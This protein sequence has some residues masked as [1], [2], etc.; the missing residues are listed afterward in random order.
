MAVL[1]AFKG[2]RPV[3]NK[4]KE[5]ASRPYDVLNCAEARK[6]ASGLPYSFLHVVKPEID[7]PDNINPYS[8]EVYKKGKANF[9]KMMDDGIMCQDQYDHLY[10]YQLT[11][12]GQTQTGLVGCCAIDDYFNNVIKKHELTRPDK[13]DDR[14]N[15]VRTGAMNAE[16]VFFSY[17]AKEEVDAIINN[18]T[19]AAP[20]YNFTARDDIQHKL[21]VVGNEDTIE[22]LV[23][24]FR[25]IESI[26]VADGHHRTAAAALVGKELREANP[27]HNGSEHYNYFM[28]VMFPDN[29][30]KIIDY[31]RVV[32]DL[33]G[34]SKDEFLNKLN[35]SFDITNHGSSTFKPSKLHEFGM[36]LDGEWYEMQAKAGTYN[37]ADPI[38]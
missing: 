29:Q 16:P 18:I 35:A 28:A 32:K 10:V 8:D 3:E 17:K 12:D 13:E 37:D 7:L 34:L 24:L 2:V 4:A 11:M 36:Y 33:N 25:G 23:I 5:V 38:A 21:W 9:L 30:L 19:K 26:Y 22:K 1:K 15:H 6:E 14:K 31:N 27:N 20:D